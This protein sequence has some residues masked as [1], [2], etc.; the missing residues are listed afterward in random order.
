MTIPFHPNAV[1]AIDFNGR[2]ACIPSNDHH[3]GFITNLTGTDTL[4]RFTLPGGPIPVPAAERDTA[5]RRLLDF[6]KR[7]KAGRAEAAMAP[8]IQP[9]I[10]GLLFDDRGRL[11]VQRIT[12]HESR[13]DGVRCG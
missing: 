5:V 8:S 6:A 2:F 12:N 11:W 9:A 3:V 1:N 13:F 10:E 4:T 7:I